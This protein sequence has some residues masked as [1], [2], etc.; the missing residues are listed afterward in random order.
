MNSDDQ[1]P[2]RS[3]LKG[4]LGAVGIAA[5]G[6]QLPALGQEK[7]GGKQGGDHHEGQRSEHARETA[8]HAEIA[9]PRR[10]EHRQL[11]MISFPLGGVCAGSIGLGGRGQLCNWEIFNRPNKGYA[12]AYCFPAIWAQVGSGKPVAHV[13]ESQLLP[14]FEGQDGTGIKECSWTEPIAGRYLHG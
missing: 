3:F 1:L 4:A 11:K 8:S 10:F 5:Q 6:V 7:G 2:R 9:Y 12:P 14:P 13:L